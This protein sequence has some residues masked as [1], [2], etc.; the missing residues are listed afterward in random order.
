MNKENIAPLE[1]EEIK[2]EIKMEAIEV[3][4]KPEV[5]PPALAIKT[6]PV[7]VAPVEERGEVAPPAEERLEETRP[8]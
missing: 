8:K 5:T 3:M 1:L 4:E 7:E 6:E 2:E